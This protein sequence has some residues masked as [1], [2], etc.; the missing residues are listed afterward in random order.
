MKKRVGLTH[1]KISLIEV[2][3]A[4]PVVHICIIFV[5]KQITALFNEFININRTTRHSYK[6][7]LYNLFTYC[8]A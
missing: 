5:G 2:Q 7:K 6:L 8:F 3:V 1:T 4:F